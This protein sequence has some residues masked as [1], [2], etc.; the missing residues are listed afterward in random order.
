MGR[1]IWAV[2]FGVIVASL[3]I[4]AL[5]WA[6]GLIFPLLGTLNRDDPDGAA[7]VLAENPLMLVGVVFTHFIGTFVGGWIGGGTARRKPIVHGLLV[8]LVMLG[9][10]IV[11]LLA[12]PHPVWFWIV[13]LTTFPIAGSLGGLLASRKPETPI[14]GL[15]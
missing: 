6:N 1:S 5:E 13:G 10:G 9:I 12:L 2:V 4:M 11:N 15:T 7:R 8:G 14:P 3:W